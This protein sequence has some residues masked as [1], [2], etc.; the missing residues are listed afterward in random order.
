MKGVCSVE[1]DTLLIAKADKLRPLIEQR[2]ELHAIWRVD[3]S[4]QDH[5]TLRFTR[6]NISAMSAAMCLVVH[7][8]DDNLITYGSDVAYYN[9]QQVDVYLS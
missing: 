9:Y 4:K 2:L 8:V 3:K 7:V 5:Y 6:D 1:I